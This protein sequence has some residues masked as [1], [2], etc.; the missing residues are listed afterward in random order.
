M[1]RK[2]IVIHVCSAWLLLCLIALPS[3][4]AFAQEPPIDPVA[5]PAV[6]QPSQEPVAGALD[7]VPPPNGWGEPAIEY[8]IQRLPPVD[9]PAKE[10]PKKNEP[11]GLGFGPGMGPGGQ[12]P[13][14]YRAFWFPS[15][16]VEGQSGDWGLVGQDLS[17]RCPVW[18]DLPNVVMF[19]AGVQNRQINTDVIM[20]DSHMKYPNQLWNVQAGMMYM[21]QLAGNRMLGGG[22]NLGSASDQ[23]FA[24]GSE[25][26]VSMNAM[27]RTPSGERNAWMFMLMYSPMGEIQFPIPCV[28]YS[29]N[30]SEQFR[31]NIGL[32]LSFTYKPDD[33][34]TF[35][36]SYMLIHTIHAKATYKLSEQ[37]SF[38]AGYDWSNEVY[39]LCNR[40]EDDDRFFLYDQRVTMGLTTPVVSWLTVELAGGYAFDRYSFSGQHWDSPETDR[41]NID[42]GPFASLVASIRR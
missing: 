8:Q 32:P 23:P 19:T 13:F 7:A 20:P 12:G 40:I 17:A 2:R 22:V 9:D 35:E 31:A 29:Y 14:R 24:S 15:V 27:Y 5:T 1:H 42:P 37:L 28:S 33:R 18:V 25:L 3:V 41:V 11:P 38:F 21:R 30:P 6:S 36:A 26:N 39:I 4:G 16:G 34:W 10:E